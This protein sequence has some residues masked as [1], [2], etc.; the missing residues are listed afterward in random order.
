MNCLFSFILELVLACAVNILSV[1]FGAFLVWLVVKVVRG[2]GRGKAYL[3]ILALHTTA[4]TTR[5]LSKFGPHLD[6]ALK[7]P[8]S[9]CILLLHIRS[10]R[11]MKS[12]RRMRRKRSRSLVESDRTST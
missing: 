4:T 12:S 5:R 8:R 2:W 10:S 6:Q 1:A 7:A 9:T 3:D 11:E